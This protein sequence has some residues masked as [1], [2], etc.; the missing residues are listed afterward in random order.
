MIQEPLLHAE[1]KSAAP[2]R[3]W[4]AG[5]RPTPR[6][7]CG[8]ASPTIRDAPVPGSSPN[9]QEVHQGGP[10]SDLLGRGRRRPAVRACRAEMDPA[11][12]AKKAKLAKHQDRV[13]GTRTG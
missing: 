11:Y 3:A 4:N 9:R 7:C 2:R 1:G 8:D 12:Q 6:H 13:A 5:S 10:E